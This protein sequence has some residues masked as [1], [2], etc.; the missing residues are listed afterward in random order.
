MKK[1]L[2]LFVNWIKN[3]F[4]KKEEKDWYDVFEQSLP[5]EEKRRNYKYWSNKRYIKAPAIH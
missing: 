3:L 1:L 4:A 2:S 5:K